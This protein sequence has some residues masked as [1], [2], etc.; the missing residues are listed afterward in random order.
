M[1]L[2]KQTIQK[3]IFSS[4]V[5]SCTTDEAVYQLESQL[6]CDWTCHDHAME[7]CQAVF[8]LSKVVL[9]SAASIPTLALQST[10]EQKGTIQSWAQMEDALGSVTYMEKRVPVVSKKSTYRKVISAIQTSPVFMPAKLNARP[11]LSNV[12]AATTFLK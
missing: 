12:G 9:L 5:A 2:Q 1:L 8:R 6:S 7:A 11:V 10:T 4:S 3:P